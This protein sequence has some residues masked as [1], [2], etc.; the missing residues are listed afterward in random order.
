M[1]NDDFKKQLAARSKPRTGSTGP[2]PRLTQA[3]HKAVLTKAM[4]FSSGTSGSGRAW[5]T[6]GCE[7]NVTGPQLG[8][9]DSIITVREFYSLFIPSTAFR[10]DAK[11]GGYKLIEKGANAGKKIDELPTLTTLLAALGGPV[12]TTEDPL[13]WAS[14]VP[15]VDPLAIPEFADMGAYD[16]WLEAEWSTI[17]NFFV[18]MILQLGQPGVEVVAKYLSGDLE[19]D[20]IKVDVKIDKTGQLYNNAEIPELLHI[21]LYEKRANDPLNTQWDR[22]KYQREKAKLD[23]QNQTENPGSSGGS[24]GSRPTPAQRPAVRP[25]QR[26]VR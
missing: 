7:L 8:K 11:N 9:T 3:Y 25:G 13:A 26:P 16:A 15:G 17:T 1:S 12:S 22:T 5:S 18:Q 2:R 14:G 23:A 19:G 6:V 20:P 4:K 21:D 24:S 10:M